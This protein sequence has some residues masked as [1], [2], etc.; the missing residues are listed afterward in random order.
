MRVG[1]DPG[2][3]PSTILLHKGRWPKFELAGANVNILNPGRKTDIAESSCVHG[4]EV[5]IRR[6]FNEAAV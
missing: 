3:P 1:F 2:V 6:A 4:V 5:K